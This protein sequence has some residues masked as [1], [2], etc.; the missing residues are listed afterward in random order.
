MLATRFVK[1][2][3]EKI[4]ESPVFSV[5]ISVLTYMSF[6][7]VL[8]TNSAYLNMFVFCY[9]YCFR[10]VLETA[11]QPSKAP[12]PVARFLLFR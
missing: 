7:I 6:C 10:N 9:A 11:G 12:F 1:L 8:F 5:N 3:L 2:M 4:A